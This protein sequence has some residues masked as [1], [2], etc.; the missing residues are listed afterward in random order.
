MM[1]SLSVLNGKTIYAMDQDSSDNRTTREIE[2]FK[3]PFY[4]PYKSYE[5]N[6]QGGPFGYFADSRDL[7]DPQNSQYEFL[8]YKI[9]LPFGIASGPLINSKFVEAAFRYNYS[10]SVY[11]TVRTRYYPCHQYPNIIPVTVDGDLTFEKASKGLIMDRDFT[12]PAAITNSFGVPSQNPKIWQ[13]DMKRA[14]ESAGIGQI[15]IASYQGTD[16]GT[17]I[18]DFVEDW[19]RGAKLVKETGAHIVE[20][21]LSCPNE[22]KKTLL[23]H[24]SE[25][26]YRICTEVKKIL[27]DSPIILKLAYFHDENELRTFVSQLSDVVQ[28]FAVINTIPAEVRKEDG[29]HA[30][31]GRLSSGI[32]GKAIKWAGLDMVRRIKKLRDELKKNFVIIG[33]GGVTT[34]SDY[35]EYRQAGADAVMC[36][37]GAM[38]NP[39]LAQ[40]IKKQEIV[41]QLHTIDVIQHGSFTLKSGASSSYY[42]DMRRIISY[43]AI[44]H[45]IIE[46][47]WHLLQPLEYD[48]ICGVPYASLSIATG[49]SLFHNI[50]MIMRRK[51]AKNYGT[52]KKIEGIYTPGSRCIVIEDVIT[53]GQSIMETITDLEAEGLSVHDIIVIVDRMQRGKKFC[54]EKGYRVHSLFTLSD[55]TFQP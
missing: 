29:S 12:F 39:M 16:D 10:L 37:T 14:V 11:K 51:E 38:W 13:P 34:P 45:L 49:V 52:Q 36:A 50:P 48:C 44:M 7:R 46:H 15:M 42:I 21:N 9:N 43:P 31:P 22:G 35:N 6:N 4:C 18:D 1:I 3:E 53:T 8:G 23:C 41:K 54:E 24:D 27:N 32:C 33:V 40:E 19:K 2:T 5:Q 17:G 28:G 30:L 47:I 20:L 25:L 55:L 26:V